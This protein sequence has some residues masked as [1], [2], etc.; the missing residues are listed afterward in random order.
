MLNDDMQE[1]K[2]SLHVMPILRRVL[3]TLIANAARASWRNEAFVYS[4]FGAYF[5][6][7]LF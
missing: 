5:I 1:Q 6:H 2:Y 3:S 7:G 4:T